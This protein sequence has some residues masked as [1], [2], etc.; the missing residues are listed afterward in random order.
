MARL[1]WHRI[2]LSLLPE[3]LTG[4]YFL[5]SQSHSD[6][7]VSCIYI[8]ICQMESSLIWFSSPIFAFLKTSLKQSILHVNDDSHCMCF[9]RAST[10]FSSFSS[11]FCVSLNFTQ[12]KSRWSLMAAWRCDSTSL[13]WIWSINITT[14]FYD[15]HWSTCH[16]MTTILLIPSSIVVIHS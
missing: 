2:H 3:I 7:C 8:H 14:S 15:K 5:Q 6:I 11:F 4:E 10:L 1:K 9:S 16:L 13:R 12:A